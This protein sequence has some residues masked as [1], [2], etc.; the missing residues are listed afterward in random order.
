NDLQYQDFSK[1]HYS[2]TGYFSDCEYFQKVMPT[3]NKVLIYPEKER[4]HLKSDYKPAMFPRYLGKIKKGEDLKTFYVNYGSGAGGGYY[5][6]IYEK[7]RWKI[8]KLSTHV[9]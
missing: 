2:F 4:Y 3:R 6:A 1:C 5:K 9:I 7:E 8:S